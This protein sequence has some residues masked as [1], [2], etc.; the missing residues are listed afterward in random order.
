MPGY[1]DHLLVGSL[2]SAILITVLSSFLTFTPE[3]IV[4]T[5]FVIL[6]GSVMPD[7][8]HREAKIHRLLRAF[9]V[10]LFG[11]TA[12]L[13]AYPAL[14]WMVV[15]G[16]MTGGGVWL[17]FESIKPQHRDITHTMRAA[18]VFGVFISTVG[19][20]AFESVMPGVLGFSAYLSHLLL[21]GTLRI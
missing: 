14:S 3:F 16:I 21:D 18:L 15:A 10:V 11:G 4:L 7:V 1:Q 9:L 20:L 19:W 12:A 5:T 17:L 2:L 6:I 8:D 13:L